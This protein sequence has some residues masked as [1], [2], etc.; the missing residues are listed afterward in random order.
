MVAL[1]KM[2][3]F[4]ERR[5]LKFWLATGMLMTSL[6][7]LISAV[8]GFTL[9]HKAIIEPLVDVASKQRHIL[10]PLQDVELSL[11]DVSKS[12]NDYAIDGRKSR[13]AD[14]QRESKEIDAAFISLAEAVEGHGLEGGEV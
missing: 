10:A 1:K 6:P 3:A 8:A 11:W 5:S 9:Y 12:V 14:Y 2:S 13:A 4:W 7:M